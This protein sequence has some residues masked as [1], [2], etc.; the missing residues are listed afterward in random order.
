MDR[1]CSTVPK[2]TFSLLASVSDSLNP[3]LS[4]WVASDERVDSWLWLWHFGIGLLNLIVLLT[5]HLP[6]MK[7]TYKKKERDHGENLQK[8][9]ATTQGKERSSLLR[10]FGRGKGR[11]PNWGLRQVP[12]EGKYEEE[13]NLFR[14]TRIPNSIRKSLFKE[15]QKRIK[16]QE[17]MEKAGGGGTHLVHL[18]KIGH[19]N[20]VVG[21]RGD[22]T[23]LVDW[24]TGAQFGA[25]F[26]FPS[27]SSCLRHF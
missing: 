26:S 22:G 21:S 18:L 6:K 13:E 25:W 23:G 19:W 4:G 2:S 15:N 5:S 7:G 3:F 9:I 16:S 27:S 20:E 8:I 12:Q 10:E 11:T 17:W 1:T 24:V 14:V